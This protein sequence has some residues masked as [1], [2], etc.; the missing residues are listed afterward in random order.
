MNTILG[1][2]QIVI[3]ALLTVGILF[4]QRGSALG[5]AFG[6]DGGGTF[7]G[8]RRGL[9]KNIY[10]STIVLGAAFIVLAVLNLIL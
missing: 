8:S 1:I 5:S 7:Y 6:Q 3:A 4:Q 2:A 9:Q 10:Y